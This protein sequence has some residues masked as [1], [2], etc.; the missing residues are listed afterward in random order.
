MAISGARISV[1]W[2]DEDHSITLTPED[3]AKVKS[4]EELSIQGEGYFYEGK[5]FLDEWHFGGGLQGEL[6][7][8]YGN[9]GDYSAVGFD[10]HL[11]GATITE[12]IDDRSDTPATGKEPDASTEEKK[13]RCFENLL[14]MRLPMARIENK[15]RDGKHSCVA[16]RCPSWCG[17]MELI[18]NLFVR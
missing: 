9:D 7:V 16:A 6:I 15:R 4:G 2:G 5:F 3:W 1:E 11:Q 8:N 12:L 10:G 17:Q 13:R 18:V 14:K